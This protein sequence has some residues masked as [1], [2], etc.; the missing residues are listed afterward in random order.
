[1]AQRGLTI[2]GWADWFCSVFYPVCPKPY[3]TDGHPDEIDLKE[4]EDF[5]KEMVERSR[6]IYA[7]E[8]QLIPRFPTGREYDEIYAPPEVDLTLKGE[9]WEKLLKAEVNTKFKL[10]KD[11]CRYPKCTFCIDNCPNNSIDFSVDPPTFDLNCNKCWFCTQICPHDAIE[12]DWEPFKTAHD[13]FVTAMLQKSLE[14]FE[15][16]GRFRRL[17]PLED[18]GWD[19]PFY[20]TKKPPR[21]KVA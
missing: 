6:R 3:F 12:V 9:A 2:I 5:G 13:P 18:I 7:G 17:V 20:K 19:T 16:K 21:F 4:A 10:N 8:T 15:A 1:M 14:V 11:R